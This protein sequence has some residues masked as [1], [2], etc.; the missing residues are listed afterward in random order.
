M[1]QRYAQ[2]SNQ[3]KHISIIIF[4]IVPLIV[5]GQEFV[6]GLIMPKP[7]GTF[8]SCCIY[9]PTSGLIAYD[10]PNGR[11][12]ALLEQAT[13]DNNGEVY[14]AFIRVDNELSEFG[15][16]NFHMVGYE[17]MAMVYTDNK[18][19]FV[20]TN[21]GYW[22]SVDELNSKGLILKTWMEYLI[23]KDDI[24]G[25]YAN[26]PGLNLRTGPS[27]NSKIAATLKGDLWEINPIKETNGL[28]CKVKATEY[29]KHP[30]SGEDNL[31]IRTLIGWVKLLSDEQTPNVWNY[32]K[33]F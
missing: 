9:I 5:S 15:Y 32:G 23:E 11:Q 31:I 25:W 21:N 27:T 8:N 30:C 29:R 19:Q 26:D 18:N 22:L 28:W 13:P 6:K 1:H 16:T 4:F 14:K 33:G 12:I 3:V 24:L 2:L 10:Q 7:D 20:K 17:I